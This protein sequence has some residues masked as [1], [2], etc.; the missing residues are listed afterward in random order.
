MVLSNAILH[1]DFLKSVCFKKVTQEISIIS[2]PFGI[3]LCYTDSRHMQ[4]TE[5]SGSRS[6][7]ACQAAT[8]VNAPVISH[9]DPLTFPC[10][11]LLIVLTG[12]I[13]F[14]AIYNSQNVQVQD[15][16]CFSVPVTV[17]SHT[18]K[19]VSSAAEIWA[20]LGTLL[21]LSLIMEEVCHSRNRC[22][23]KPDLWTNG[24]CCSLLS[25]SKFPFSHPPQLEPFQGFDGISILSE[26]LC[27]PSVRWAR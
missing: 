9:K 4:P 22:S 16:I 2:H 25:F 14:E 17:S 18:H 15:A 6:F 7:V 13:A 19:K 21:Q 3:I 24:L 27:K 20:L 23:V 26:Q 10:R 8:G 11:P 5:T 12:D 1:I